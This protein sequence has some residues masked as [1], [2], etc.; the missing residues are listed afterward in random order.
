[1]TA[2]QFDKLDG[3]EEAA[4]VTDATNVDAAGAV[5]EA[6][7]NAK[8][9]LLTATA[10]NEPI[11]KYLLVNES[12]EIAA[13]AL[14]C[15]M[16]YKQ[17]FFE[18]VDMDKFI[19]SENLDLKALAYKILLQ[20]PELTTYERMMYLHNIPLFETIKYHE[21]HLLASSTQTLSFEPNK[22]II[23]QGGV[24]HTLFII[25]S[26]QVSV[27]VDGKET[28]RLGDE[29]YFGAVAILADTRRVAS[30][31]SLTNVTMLT[32]SKNA[33]KKFLYE[34]PRI[35]IKLM[36]EVISK[37]IEKPKEG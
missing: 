27:E 32:L 37:L 14:L 24:A 17:E 16:D 34:N 19:Q 30:V 35:S 5:M 10:D 36:K 6:D 15:A 25:T 3:I 22:Y 28:G 33:F 31:K 7:F 23:E 29:D 2:T 1:M 9:D 21:L 18:N 26:G 11:I 13:A 8:G 20:T 12:A 4:D